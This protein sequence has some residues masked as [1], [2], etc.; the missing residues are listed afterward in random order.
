MTPIPLD[1]D[2]N[3][4]FKEAWKNKTG[5]DDDYLSKSRYLICPDMDKLPLVGDGTDCR[6]S[7]PCSY[8]SF[9]IYKHFGPTD[10]CNPIDYERIV[11]SI[12]YI[13]PELIVDDFDNP[14]SYDIDTTWT[15]FSE[16]QSQIMI[17]NHF[18]ISLETHARRFGLNS[19]SDI[20]KKLVR[21]H[22]VRIDKSPFLPLANYPYL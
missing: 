22:D 4:K 13:N 16:T 3:A 18:Y 10:H 2:C 5:E 11:V 6:D 7:G 19:L 8:Y 15:T 21:N 17:I 9:R 1:G 14:W 12:S 20:D